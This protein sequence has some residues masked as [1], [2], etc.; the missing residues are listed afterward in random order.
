MQFLKEIKGNIFPLES[1]TMK[2]ALAAKGIRKKKKK[3]SDWYWLKILD[4]LA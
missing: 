3:K 1:S 4:I 2:L